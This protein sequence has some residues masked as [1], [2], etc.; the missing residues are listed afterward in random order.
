MKVEV[1]QSIRKSRNAEI[2]YWR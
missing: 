1:L 2:M